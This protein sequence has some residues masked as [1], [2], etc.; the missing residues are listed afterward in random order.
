[1]YLDRLTLLQ[2]PLKR[3]RADHLSSA[4]IADYSNDSAHEDQIDQARF[5][6]HTQVLCSP[7]LLSSIAFSA[8]FGFPIA[9]CFLASE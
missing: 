9:D 4:H 1:M 6:F 7:R 3:N 2:A 5:S 8:G